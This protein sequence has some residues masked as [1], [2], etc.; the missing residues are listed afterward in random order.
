MAIHHFVRLV[1]QGS[2]VPVFGD[3]SARRDFTYVDDAVA[4]ILAALDRPHAFEVVNLG[5]S[6]VVELQEVIRLI[7]E[8]VGKPARIE[9]RPMQAGDAAVNFSDIREGVSILG[10]FARTTINERN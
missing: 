3:G 7:E 10:F 2:P 6:H 4:G 5:V 9:W 8:A 1:E